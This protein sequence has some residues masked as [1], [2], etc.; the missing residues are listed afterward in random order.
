MLEACS[1]TVLRKTDEEDLR[2]RVREV[3]T[4]VFSLV[5][6]PIE[7]DREVLACAPLVANSAL[8]LTGPPGSGKNTLTAIIGQAYFGDGEGGADMA[9]VT[10]HP[11]LTANEVLHFLDLPELMQGRQVVHPH[12]LVTRRLKYINE[13]QRASPALQNALLSLFSEGEVRYRLEEPMK[14]PESIFIL[15]RNPADY[16]SREL[17]PAFLDRID[18]GV[19][20]QTPHLCDSLNIRQSKRDV[21][22]GGWGRLEAQ[23]DVHLGVQGVLR[24]WREVGNIAIPARTE[25]RANMLLEAFRLCVKEERSTVNSAF[26]LD[27][28]SCGFRGEICS[29]LESVP[30]H[31]PLESLLKLG[32]AWA[33]RRGESFVGV[34]CLAQLV[35]F[36]LGHRLQLRRDLLRSVAQPMNWIE[37][38]AV[39]QVIASKEKIWGQAADAFLE[40]DRESLEDIQN[41]DLVVRYLAM[42]FDH[43]AAEALR[44]RHEVESRIEGCGARLEPTSGIQ[45]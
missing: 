22:A 20:M 19:V 33:W 16:A 11:D 36:V 45:A 34:D 17:A 41:N 12:A 42:L 2:D 29:H 26:D 38:V 31:R 25:L 15:D 30:G 3:E 28:S 10:C 37:D 35:P 8:L 14:S 39:G 27:C 24:V 21:K 13:I 7:I 43:P 6:V 44:R 9:T 5:Q 40:G 1:T 4:C 23:V 18:F 32:Q